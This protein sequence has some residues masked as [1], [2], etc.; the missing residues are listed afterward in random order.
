MGAPRTAVKLTIRPLLCDSLSG[1]YKTIFVFVVVL[2][3]LCTRV[4]WHEG[5]PL[6]V[7]LQTRS[8]PQD[9]VRRAKGD[10]ALELYKDK[11]RREVGVARV[12]SGHAMVVGITRVESEGIQASG[13]R[14][15]G[16]TSR[17]KSGT[18][19]RPPHS[20]PTARIRG[21]CRLGRSSAKFAIPASVGNPKTAA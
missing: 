17:S 18:A 6:Q 4:S 11:T 15:C 16:R 2:V 10:E 5:V 13:S 21:C 19:H 20:S 1:S 14:K 3:L 9:R 8:A 12:G 7:T